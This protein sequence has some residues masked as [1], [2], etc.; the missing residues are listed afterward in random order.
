MIRFH[1]DWRGLSV[2]I[3]SASLLVLALGVSPAPAQ[4]KGQTLS[5]AEARKDAD[6]AVQGEYVG[7]RTAGD[8]EGKVGLQLVAQGQGKFIGVAYPGGLPGA[9]WT[10]K[11]KIPVTGTRKGDVVE[12]IGGK[13]GA[14]GSGTWKDGRIL[15]KD[16]DGNSGTFKR[17]VRISP[18]M[19]ARLPRRLS[20][21]LTGRPPST[22]RVAGL[23]R[24]CF[25]RE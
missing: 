14:K 6:H 22:S 12:L 15:Y 13:D 25:A 16:E 3:L 2:P 7:K 8:D 9:G 1:P 21:S 5:E 18:T 23:I 17:V 11:E 19:G 20:C 4:N 24:G 10:G